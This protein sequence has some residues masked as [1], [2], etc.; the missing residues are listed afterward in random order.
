[1][2]KFLLSFLILFGFSLPVMGVGNKPYKYSGG[3]NY[4]WGVSRNPQ[5][6][7][8]EAKLENIK[9]TRKFADDSAVS[10][11]KSAFYDDS[12]K[13]EDLFFQNKLARINPRQ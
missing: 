12:T 10:K 2:K 4:G 5:V 6:E 11:I 1:M 8:S 7:L 3:D 13:S 9:E